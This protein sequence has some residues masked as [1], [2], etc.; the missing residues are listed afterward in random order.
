M[1]SK[2]AYFDMDGTICAPCFMTPEGHAMGFI[3]Q[4]WPNYC[5]RMGDIAYDHCKPVKRVCGYAADL[6]C[7]GYSTKILTVVSSDAELGA[8]KR[9]LDRNGL[10]WLFDELIAVRS[11]E[12]KVPYI[13]DRARKEGLAP[14]NCM[15]VEDTL[16]TAIAAANAGI[17]AR[18]LSHIID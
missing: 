3:G 4:D 17:D 5:T 16:L 1:P 12:E 11:P 14:M 8:K 18:H 9:W 13:L 7:K 6:K 2:I 15:L 10:G